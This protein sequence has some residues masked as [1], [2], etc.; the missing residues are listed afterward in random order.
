M[1]QP[2]EIC[3]VLRNCHLFILDIHCVFRKLFITND[4][5]KF[6][7]IFFD[8]NIVCRFSM[9][10]YLIKYIFLLLGVQSTCPQ[11]KNKLKRYYKKKSII[12]MNWGFEKEPF[13]CI[14]YFSRLF[15]LEFI[16]PSYL[17]TNSGAVFLF[18]CVILNDKFICICHWD[19]FT[20]Q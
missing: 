8:K 16:Y 6:N 10:P 9:A 1:L 2:E 19:E 5:Q 11:K 4:I 17:S 13:V 14:I 12:F 18:S 7:E 3:F 15:L 20:I